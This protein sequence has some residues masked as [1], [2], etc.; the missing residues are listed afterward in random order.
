MV[1][2]WAWAGVS[3]TRQQKANPNEHVNTKAEILSNFILLRHPFLRTLIERS[4]PIGDQNPSGA[5][6]TLFANHATHAT[7]EVAHPPE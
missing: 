7:R 3:P 6:E 4:K 1:W 5:S 2:E